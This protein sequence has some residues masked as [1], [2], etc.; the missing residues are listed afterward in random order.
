MTE[1]QSPSNQTDF[2]TVHVIFCLFYD[3]EL[4][5]E[6]GLKWNYESSFDKFVPFQRGSGSKSLYF[7]EVRILLRLTLMIIFSLML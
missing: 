1:K 6:I 7:W 5:G 4:F 3:G 2:K